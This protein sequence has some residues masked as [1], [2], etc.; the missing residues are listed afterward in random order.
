MELPPVAKLRVTED[1]GRSHQWLLGD[2]GLRSHR[3]DGRGSCWAMGTLHSPTARLC[4]FL[5]SPIVGHLRGLC[6]AGLPT[7]EVLFVK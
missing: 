1:N 7:V 4:V 6:D 2:A 3:P 5:S